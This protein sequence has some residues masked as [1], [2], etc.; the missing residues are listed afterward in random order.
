VRIERRS[1]P[2]S[3][4]WPTNMRDCLALRNRE[5]KPNEALEIS[6]S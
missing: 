1:C 2:A 4:N 3:G 5:K 6:N